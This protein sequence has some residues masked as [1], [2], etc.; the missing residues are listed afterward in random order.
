MPVVSFCRDRLL[1]RSANVSAP[2][3][4]NP[5][6]PL[7]KAAATQARTWL[8]AEAFEQDGGNVAFAGIGQDGNDGFAFELR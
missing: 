2:P 3:N 8:L 4:A 7:Q 5:R 1:R 6:R